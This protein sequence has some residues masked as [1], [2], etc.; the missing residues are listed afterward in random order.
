MN[1]CF[2][3]II[4]QMFKDTLKNNKHNVCVTPWASVWIEIPIASCFSPSYKLE[5]ALLERLVGQPQTLYLLCRDVIYIV[6]LI[7]DCP[8]GSVQP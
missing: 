4:K 5:G 7:Y 1:D 2:S 6:D 3:I 8:K